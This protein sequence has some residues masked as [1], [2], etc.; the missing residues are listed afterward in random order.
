MHPSPI[1]PSDLR[2]PGQLYLVESRNRA[3]F[4]SLLICPWKIL[5]VGNL[6]FGTVHVSE[7]I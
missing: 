1:W 5:T 6:N 2:D 7:I 3:Y 4:L